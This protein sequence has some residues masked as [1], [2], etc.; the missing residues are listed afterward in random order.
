MNDRP[1]PHQALQRVKVG[2]IGLVAVAL[3]IALASMIIG[4]ATR[5]RS[6]GV[7]ATSNLVADMVQ[8][9][10]AAEGEPL[11]EMGVAPGTA[12]AAGAAPAR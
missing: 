8:T 10:S 12:N 11:A 9:N 5:G 6:T 7:A 3:L 1:D 4:S 2:V